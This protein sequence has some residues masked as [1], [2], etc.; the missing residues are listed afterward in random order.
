MRNLDNTVK[1]Q[2]VAQLTCC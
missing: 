1:V 2:L